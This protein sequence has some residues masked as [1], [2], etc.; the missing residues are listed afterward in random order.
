MN[1]NNSANTIT[2]D[3][4]YTPAGI[5]QRTN[6]EG[7]IDQT[8]IQSTN[9][10]Y[11]S[12]DNYGKSY[13]WRG[14]QA[15]NSI[16][17]YMIFAGIKW[18]ILRINGNGTLR[19]ITANNYEGGTWFNSNHNGEYDDST[20]VGYMY[21]QLGATTY[22]DANSNLYDSTIKQNLDD[23]YETNIKDKVSEKY[24]SDT[25]FCNDRSLYSGYGYGLNYA[26]YNG[27]TRYKEWNPILSCPQKNDAFTVSDTN[28]GNGKL[29]YAIGL[30]TI[31][32]LMMAGYTY[33]YNNIYDSQ[34]QG[35]VYLNNN[36]YTDEEKYYSYS[37][38][39]KNES[40]FL[41]FG[42]GISE[43]K[44]KNTMTHWRS[45]TDYTYTTQDTLRPVINIDITN[46]T[47][48]GQGTESNPFVVS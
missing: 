32:E 7:N 36:N 40:Y 48:T 19:L 14:Q 30:I 13:F 1:P 16:D 44:V 9:G 18:R 35:D 38:S 4:S 42:Q 45:Y 23:W 28:F 5:R 46:A 21:G 6:T 37:M 34:H 8:N 17:N 2:I 15:S 11:I 31:D 25:L 39:P 3:F 20:Y 33:Y 22:T 47:V 29:T 41:V 12:E 26:Y 10:V 27:N 43:L 24:I